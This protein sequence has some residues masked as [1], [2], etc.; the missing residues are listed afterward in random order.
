VRDKLPP[1]PLIL[2]FASVVLHLAAGG[3]YGIFRDEL[4]RGIRMPLDEAWERGRMFI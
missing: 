2:A 1:V 4:C 3:R